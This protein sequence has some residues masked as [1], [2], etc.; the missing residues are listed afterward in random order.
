[1]RYS[2]P[3]IA[4]QLQQ[5]QQRQQMMQQSQMQM[6]REPSQMDMNG[7]ARGSPA[8]TN[9]PSPSKR[10]RIDDGN[11]NGQ[12]GGPAGRGQPLSGAQGNPVNAIANGPG[13]M[14]LQ[15]GMTP[16]MQQQMASF[17]NGPNMQQKSMEVS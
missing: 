6:Q 3:Q 15:N 5:Q 9:A 2:N 14:L 11:F 13:G 7:Q 1:M 17:Q 8:M 16:E 10:P 4:A 12:P